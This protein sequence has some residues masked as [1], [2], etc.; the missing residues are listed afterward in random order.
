[1][2]SVLRNFQPLP[3]F[4]EILFGMRFQALIETAIVKIRNLG[5]FA[6]SKQTVYNLETNKAMTVFI[7]KIPTCFLFV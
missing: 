3:C 6:N 5:V 2:Y 7:T 1:M 4:V